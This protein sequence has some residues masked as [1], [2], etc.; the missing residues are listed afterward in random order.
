[1]SKHIKLTDEQAEELREDL[2]SKK[3]HIEEQL[4]KLHESLN[5]G[6]DVDS[7]ERETDESEAH[8]NAAGI[9]DALKDLLR[10]IKNGLERLEE[11]EHGICLECDDKIN[12]EALKKNPST[13]LCSK[14]RVQEHEEG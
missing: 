1:M 11:G 13:R 8:A 7:G 4:D 12:F 6:D 14:C 5:M 3:E 2:L 10:D 9:E